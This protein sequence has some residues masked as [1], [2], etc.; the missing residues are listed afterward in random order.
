MFYP[1]AMTEIEL[2][3]PSK[4]M[5]AVTK[6]LSGRGLF[7]QTDASYLNRDKELTN[8]S[9]WHD[10]STAYA[11]L[12]R[13][14]Q[15][16]LQTLGGHEGIPPTSEFEVM[17]EIENA[18][19]V[20]DNIE[21]EVKKITDHLANETKRLEQ[22]ESNLN[23]LEPIEELDVQ[24]S[25]LRN[26]RF[27]YSILG[28]MPVNNI[29]RLHDSLAR[30]PFVFLTLRQENQ[31]A[32]VWIAGART[33]AE[34]LDRAI[35][36]AYLIPLV[37]PDSYHGTPAEI[38]KMLREHSKTS[39]EQ[40]AQFNIK[41]EAVREVREKELQD[42]YWDI[43]A[44]HLMTDAII[45][46]G[47]LKYTY[48]VIGW[49]PSNGL[50]D[51]VERIKLVSRET[52][53]ESFPTKRSNMQK[54]VPVDLQHL[55]IFQSFQMMVMTY[56]RPRYDELDP[57]ILLA[58]SF[59][60]IYGAMFGDVGQGI[61]LALIGWLLTSRKVKALQSLASL[62]GLVISCGVSA[63]V[64][65]FLYG[66]IFGFEDVLPILWIR[67][68]ENIILILEI[69]VGAGIFMLTVGF[70]IGILNAIT[71]KD[72]PRLLFEK[73][74][75]PGFLL[76]WGILGYAGSALLGIKAIPSFV[77][78]VIIALSALAIMFS[79]VLK[80]LVERHRPLISGG[81]G[82]FA[83]QAVFEVFETLISFLS[84]S[85]SYVRIGAFAVAHGGLSQAI[86]IL[87]ALVSPG[88]GPGYFLVLL[89]GNLFIIGFEGLIVGIQTMRLEYYE[90]FSKFFVGGGK[91]YEP[92][93]LRPIAKD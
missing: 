12:E 52:L 72:W 6:E 82:T 50:E 93:A 73:N 56:A 62:G 40:I 67:P 3:V 29:D 34:I 16:I 65:G 20:V 90:F 92:L 33:N 60:I 17:T 53:I 39:Q 13:R 2:V 5:L 87:G 14:I 79:E 30:I 24:I 91:R 55:K 19:D 51:L 74:G 69:A 1:Q 44:S 63:T 18:V 75:L 77:F 85:L 11:S 4:D 66:S 43:H 41:L 32:V 27:I 42:L 58:I 78:I 83:I 35:R 21:A 36:S 54:E 23:Q 10:K 26:Q 38:I 84:N 31:K 28:I 49:T 80:H 45:R 64:F 9:I 25:A 88:H 86:F 8:S 57:T 7:H 68:I 15:L 70:F 76:Y 46:Y 71:A 22:L 37:L 48:L 47:R 59:P 81:A 61:V 89:L